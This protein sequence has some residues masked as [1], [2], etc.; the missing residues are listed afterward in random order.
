MA[1]ATKIFLDG[2]RHGPFPGS[3]T[4]G[5]VDGTNAL[6]V[7]IDKHGFID[8]R[9]AAYMLATTYHETAHTMQ[10][11][12]EYGHGRGRVYGKPTG[13][14]HCIYDGRGDVQLTWEANYIHATKRLRELSAIGD[15]IDLDRN[16]ELAMRPDIAAAIMIYGMIEGWFTGKRLSD[17]FNAT[18]TDPVGARHIINGTDRAQ[19]IA[20]YYA[21]FLEDLNAA[22][23]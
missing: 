19:L 11:I 15:D 17:Y 13:P 12:E 14:W 18:T 16:P 20:G 1:L 3:L 9:W 5:Q 8:P 2:I 6:L 7:A 10:P 22:G 4:Q 21:Q 23:A